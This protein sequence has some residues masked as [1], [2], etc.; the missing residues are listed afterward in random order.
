MKVDIIVLQQI[1]T[2]MGSRAKSRGRSRIKVW[3]Q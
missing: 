1:Y 3:W 2:N